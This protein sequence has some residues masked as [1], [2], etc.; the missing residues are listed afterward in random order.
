MGEWDKDGC[1]HTLEW[2]LK[3]ES[4]SCRFYQNGRC[5][6]YP[7]RPMLCS[8]YPFYLDEGVLQYSLCRGIGGVIE[9]AEA[10]ELAGRVILRSILELTEAI[11]LTEKFEDF[12]SG[13]NPEKRRLCSSR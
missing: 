4:E 2:R 1:F 10:K 8:T 13:A 7:S 5:C 11:A 6:I 12:E 9:P 3:K